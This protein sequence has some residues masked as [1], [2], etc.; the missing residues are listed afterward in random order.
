VALRTYPG[1]RCRSELTVTRSGGAERAERIGFGL[2]KL[3]AMIGDGL[4]GEVNVRVY[5]ANEP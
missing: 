1:G 2:P 4:H 3:D 5:R